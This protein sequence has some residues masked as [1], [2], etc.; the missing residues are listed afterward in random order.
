MEPRA[1]GTVDVWIRCD[2]EG[3]EDRGSYLRY[4]LGCACIL[5]R[6]SANQRVWKALV[7]TS[8]TLTESLIQAALASRPYVDETEGPLENNTWAS[9]QLTSIAF[10]VQYTSLNTECG[11]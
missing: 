5:C 11:L 6:I 8:T 10:S 4:L 3:I 7:S 2:V 9:H 1:S